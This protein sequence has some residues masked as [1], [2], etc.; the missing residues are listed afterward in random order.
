MHFIF[1]P[2]AYHVLV[3]VHPALPSYPMLA[4]SLKRPTLIRQLTPFRSTRSFSKST[5]RPSIAGG[6]AL[7]ASLVLGYSVYADASLPSTERAPTPLSKLVTSY[8]VYSLCS[9]PGLVDASPALL[10]FCTSVPG[11]RQLTEAFVRATFFTQ[12]AP[13]HPTPMAAALT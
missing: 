6:G 12:V 11:L 10:A 5:R 2:S 13:T 9:I 4:Q 3:I 8:V 7:A 1:K